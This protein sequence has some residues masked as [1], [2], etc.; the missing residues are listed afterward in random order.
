MKSRSSFI[1]G[2]VMGAVLVRLTSIILFSGHLDKEVGGT[3]SEFELHDLSGS[4]FT[5]P[6]LACELGKSI[7][8]STSLVSEQA[9]RDFIATQKSQGKITEMS[10]YFRDLNNGPWIGIDEDKPY[11]PA[12]LAKVPILITYLKLAEQDAHLLETN[13]DYI[14]QVSVDNAFF[15]PREELEVGKTYSIN[16][17]LRRMI[18]YSDNESLALLLDHIEPLEETLQKTFDQTDVKYA[19]HTDDK[20]S[21]KSYASFFRILYNASYL[22]QPSSEYA[23]KLLSMSDF[24]QGLVHGLPANIKVAHKFGER[25]SAGNEKQLHDCGIVYVPHHPYLLCVMTKGNDFDQLAGVISD[26][27]KLVYTKITAKAD[28]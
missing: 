22:S 9:L 21:V 7:Q 25:S 8:S 24:K 27:S 1:I 13:V 3:L 17:L 11:A 4:G 18:V 2:L 5:S 10:V 12:S 20:I 16:E 15:K 28:N 19:V 26:V 23:L 14:K 6:L